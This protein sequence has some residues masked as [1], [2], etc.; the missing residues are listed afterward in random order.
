M[1]SPFETAAAGMAATLQAAAGITVTYRRGEASAEVTAVPSDR[2]IEVIGADGLPEIAHL[3]DW[4]ITAAALAA[5][6]DP[7]AGDQIDETRGTTLYTW[8]VMPPTPGEPAFSPCDTARQSLR[9][10]TK[11]TAETET[12]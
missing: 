10:H 3:R 9:I 5:F 6:G 7:A 4:I 2:E 8:D 1:T 12:T 11:A